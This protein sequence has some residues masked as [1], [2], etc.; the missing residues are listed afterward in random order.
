ML[1]LNHKNFLLLLLT[2]ISYLWFNS[3]YADD[4]VLDN[5]GDGLGDGTAVAN[6][7]NSSNK[8]ACGN[9]PP[10]GVIPPH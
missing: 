4:C 10:L 6:S 2:L 5:D 7:G 3:V 8:V 9:Q 1:I